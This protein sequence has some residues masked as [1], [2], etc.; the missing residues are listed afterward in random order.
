MNTIRRKSNSTS[1]AIVMALSCCLLFMP[2]AR[3]ASDSVER[4]NIAMTDTLPAARPPEFRLH[5]G[6]RVCKAQHR[7]TGRDPCRN[8]EHHTCEINAAVAVPR[9]DVLSHSSR[10]LVK[11]SF[12]FVLSERLAAI[13]M[14]RR[15]T[16]S[17]VWPS[18]CPGAAMLR[19]VPDEDI[20]A[21][22]GAPYTPGTERAITSRTSV[23][24]VVG[25][26]CV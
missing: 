21:E 25:A 4:W 24:M 11:N 12:D 3:G 8:G 7:D 19:A 20:F 13:P 10:P 2:V 26:G 6:P 5:R 18:C 14:A 1:A 17:C 15:D 16:R 22:L 9:T 23:G